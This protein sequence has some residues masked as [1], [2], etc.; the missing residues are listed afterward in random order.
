[1]QVNIIKSLIAG[2]YIISISNKK[3]FSISKNP[4]VEYVI[5]PK[6]DFINLY[7]TSDLQEILP[8]THKHIGY[9]FNF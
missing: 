2:R 7:C 3:A 6:L 1:M 4:F 8:N 5:F 9:K